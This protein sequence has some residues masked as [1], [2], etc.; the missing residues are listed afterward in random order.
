MPQPWMWL[1][2]QRLKRQVLLSKQP[3]LQQPQ[4]TSQQIDVLGTTGLSGSSASAP[5]TLF[6]LLGSKAPPG[7]LAIVDAKPDEYY[8]A[9]DQ[10]REALSDLP[11]RLQQNAESQLVDWVH[12]TDEYPSNLWMNCEYA[13]K[14]CEH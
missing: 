10:I 2:N 9:S 4:V 7:L 3:T 6:F 13:Q 14:A 1:A 11:E 8:Q 12:S 5:G